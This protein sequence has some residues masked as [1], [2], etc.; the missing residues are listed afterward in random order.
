MHDYLFGIE[1]VRFAFI[2]GVAV[3]MY[4]YER[5]H[6]TTGSIVVP[7]YIAVFILHPLVL[8]ATFVNA[9]ASYWVINRLLPRYVL[10][11]GRTKF[12]VLVLTSIV[13]QTVML[14]ISPSAPWLWESD[15][16]LF[17]GA[18]Y[19]IPALIAH[20]M[21]RQG[22][23]PTVKAVL[24]TGTIVSVPILV[25]LLFVPSVQATRPLVDFAV[26]AFDPQFV[27]IAVIIGALASWGLL[28]NHNLRTGGFIGAAY[29][30]ML[31]ATGWQI[32]YL[33]GAALVTWFLV[34]KVLGRVII[35]FGRRKF[36]TMLL[37]GAVISWS[38]LAMATSFFGWHDQAF[39]NLASVALTPLFLPG[40]LAN[41]ME[42]SSPRQVALGVTV[43][44][45]FVLAG[46]TWV[47]ELTNGG[48][49]TTIWIAGSVAMLVAGFIFDKQIAWTLMKLFELPRRGGSLPANR[50]EA[51]H[52]VPA[53]DSASSVE[54][55]SVAEDPAGATLDDE[56]ELLE[57][58]A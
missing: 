10:L 39:S 55:P 52:D 41:D 53:A 44:G 47:F 1:A 23:K 21:G 56:R 5:R 24:S 46:I 49:S 12:S 43:G 54:E 3:S 2:L 4:L 35:L 28:A 48:S 38:G 26:L 37:V 57:T 6:V 16:P 20:D 29:L 22:I 7:G 8:L 14:K 17:V 30:A 32:A 36:S 50:L 40:L 34:T 33:F 58:A 9:L 18:G 27:P 51:S 13:L 11:Y 45:T 31:S 25:A 42:R 15:V 19:V